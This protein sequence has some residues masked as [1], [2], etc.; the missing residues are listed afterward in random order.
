MV[1][2]QVDV[3]EQDVYIVDFI[4]QFGCVLVVVVNK[5]DGF[6]VYMCEQI[7]LILQCKLKFF[8]FVKFYFILVCD[9]I[10]LELLFC[11]VDV[12]FVVVMIKML[13][14]CLVW[15]FVDVVVKQVLFKYGLF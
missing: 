3:L 2:V 10:G 13:I 11:L 9:N 8:D 4:V 5:W 15:V 6:D 7:W 12:V 1:D 14:L